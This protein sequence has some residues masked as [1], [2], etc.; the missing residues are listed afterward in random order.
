MFILY[1][2]GRYPL[3]WLR[4]VLARIL[5]GLAAVLGLAA[6]DPV[7]RSPAAPPLTH[8]ASVWSPSWNAET[9][10]ALGATQLDPRLATLRIFIGTAGQI[11]EGQRFPVDW[12][13]VARAR[14]P[15]ELSVVVE[16]GAFAVTPNIDL[17][18]AVDF[19]AESLAYARAAEVRV[20]GVQ[21]ELD[22]PPRHLAALAKALPAIRSR[23]SLPVGV[24]VLPSHLKESG[25][26]ELVAAAD[27]LT[28]NLMAG[29]ALGGNPE[30][31]KP[32]IL[33]SWLTT[34]AQTGK[35]FRV[36]LSLSSYYRCE[37][38]T[39]RPLG[40]ILVGLRPLPGTHRLRHRAADPDELARIWQHLQRYAPDTLVG[41]DWFRL[42]VVDDSGTWSREGLTA[43]LDNQPLVR[44]L[45]PTVQSDDEGNYQVILAN[46]GMVP[47]APREIEVTWSG[48]PLETRG[49]TNTFKILKPTGVSFQLHPSMASAVIGPGEARL[50]GWARFESTPSDVK[51]RLVG[52]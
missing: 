7:P 41:V 45:V 33:D 25:Y 21:L 47:L 19:L 37:D 49:V 31:P 28:L 40:D 8:S 51:V 30:V 26:A 34:A 11:N 16:R 9:A 2:A 46:S 22:C 23:L 50:V 17:T 13:A 44:S 36:G 27:S 10:L 5:T 32:A 43:V 42:P 18:R 24:T 6:C 12:Q 35:P 20:A 29:R 38:E 39:G 52:P 48:A 3:V 4:P 15:V 14:R 1:R